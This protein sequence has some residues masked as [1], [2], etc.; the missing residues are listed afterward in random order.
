MSSGE[1]DDAVALEKSGQPVQAIQ[2]YQNWLNENRGNER[3]TDI[4]IHTASLYDNPLDSLNFMDSYSSSLLQA[5]TYRVYAR[6]AQLES[7][8]GLLHNAAN[9]YRQA[10]GYEGSEGKQWLYN[11]LSIRFSMGE[12][13]EVRIEALK[14][15]E[16]A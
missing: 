11:S 16:E 7:S 8:L 10:S 13:T 14:L 4:L 1:L 9:H 5:D 12:Y 3:Y 15:A 2:A 6:M